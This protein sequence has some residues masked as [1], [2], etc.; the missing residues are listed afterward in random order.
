MKKAIFI[1]GTDTG[2]GKT[3]TS[4]L[5]CLAM[6]KRGIDCV[7]MK[8]VETGA[9]RKG[10]GWVWPDTEFLRKVTKPR[11]ENGL[12][13]P[14]RFKNPLAPS[15][16]AR[17]E[18]KKIDMEGIKRAFN[19]LMDKHQ[20]VIVEGAGGLFVPLWNNFLTADL[21]KELDIPIIIVSRLSLGT[22]NHTLLTIEAARNSGIEVSGIIFNQTKA[23]KS[24]IIEKTNPK[25]ISSIS[26]VSVLG[27][28]PYLS[29]VSVEKNQT[30]GLEK[31]IRH[32]KIG[33]LLKKSG[34]N[35]VRLQNW[36]KKYIWHPFT[37]MQDWLKDKPLVI[38]EGRGAYL[39]DTYGK[40]YLDG[41]SSLWVNLHGHRKKELDDAIRNQL[42]KIS[43]STLLGLANVPAI[44]LAKRLIEISPGKLS[45]V[46]YSD[47]G[48]TAVEIGLKIAFQYWQQKS[49]AVKTK[50]KFIHFVNAYHGDTLGAV[51]VGGIDLFH[52]V[53]QPL[54]FNSFKVN[55]PYCYRC[56]LGL[57]LPEC[58]LKC[59]E[60]TERI[61]KKHHRQIAGLIIEPAI[62]AAAGML[63]QP[64]GFLKNIE[65]LCRKYR[66][67]L[68][69]D[70][71]ATGFG[72]T[73]KMF[74]C[75]SED[76]K[77]D[78][79]CLAKGISG[80]YLP[81]AATLATEEIFNGF[82][83]EYKDKK[84]FFHGHTYTGN[85]LACSVAI[86]S[87]EVFKKE[88]VLQRLQPQISHIKKRLEE[89]RRLK[90][91]GEIRQR[92]F[93]AGIELVRDKKTRLSY[94]WADKIGVRVCREAR[95]Y[96]VLLRPLGD[97]VVLM[98]PLS[99]TKEEINKL[100]GVAYRS[101]K[102]VTEN[103]G[104]Y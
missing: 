80:G 95:E 49:D 93:M 73:G 39:K 83:G 16:A 43:H 54:L 56:H 42:N 82:L 69:C 67:L 6:Q 52:R 11:E 36:D 61:L 84:T 72:R 99:I 66:V 60:D 5:I 35:S 87:L 98:P 9:I 27:V 86:A 90:H 19:N 2:V 23:G 13:S 22:I 34:N 3:V 71:V 89:F 15:L 20:V 88:R 46:F 53:Y 28:V 97:V 68:I 70:E 12:L 18:G 104:K 26:G 74:A 25:I 75:E 14:F 51:S 41:I 55:S 62:Y 38:E 37:Q 50:N 59:I 101:I 32:I 40:W 48:S 76:I 63:I 65:R 30:G 64:R 81:L 92:G 78:I 100:L 24:G 7:V 47:D 21:V 103:E 44:E 85:P 79:L 29:S 1:T 33:S 8:P 94:N 57:A 17:M 96:G 77:P 45:K 31:A 10:K 102:K 91:V 4:A 58:K